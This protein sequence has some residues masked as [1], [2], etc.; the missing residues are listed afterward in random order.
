MP[1]TV[2]LLPPLPA[3]AAPAAS[4]L[5]PLSHSC[6]CVVEDESDRKICRKW[7][8]RWVI[9]RVIEHVKG[10]GS[11]AVCLLLGCVSRY[12]RMCNYTRCIDKVC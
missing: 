1:V 6:G 10:G 3:L 12:V 5:P 2:L 11:E 7:S 8:I 4:L 9:I